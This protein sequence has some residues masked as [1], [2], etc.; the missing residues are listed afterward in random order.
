[1]ASFLEMMVHEVLYSVA[2]TGKRRR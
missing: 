2:T 1:V